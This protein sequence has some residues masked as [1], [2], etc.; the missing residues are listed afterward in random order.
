[1]EQT[2]PI[3]NLLLRLALFA[4]LSLG[5]ATV[6]S[7]TAASF[8]AVE[9]IN[10]QAKAGVLCGRTRSHYRFQSCSGGESLNCHTTGNLA[11]L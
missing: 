2:H 11:G 9:L 6:V 7:Q 10:A 3:R 8:A 4:T 5:T 1:M